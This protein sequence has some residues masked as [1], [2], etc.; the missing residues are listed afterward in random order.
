MADRLA[1]DVTPL[2]SVAMPVYNAGD[3]LRKAV[4]SIL[5]QT[6]THWEL[7]IIDDGSTDLALQT[8]KDFVDPR[9]RIF[10][11]GTN[12]G[13][14]AR[15]NEAMYLARGQF[16]ARMDQDDVSYPSRFAR[17]LQ[18][19]QQNPR[20]DV[21]A[22][23]A[24]TIDE[25]DAMTGLF[26]YAIS[27]RE[28]GA[29][30]WR[31]FYFPHPTWMGKIEWFRKHRYAVPAPYFCED[32]ELLLRTYPESQFATVNEILFG[33]RVRSQVDFRKLQKTRLAVFKI[34]WRCFGNT[35]Q[36]GYMLLA[37]ATLAGRIVRDHMSRIGP[38]FCRSSPRI[39]NDDVSTQ[40]R[41]VLDQLADLD[42]GAKPRLGSHQ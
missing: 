11:D 34:Q 39:R 28:I 26:P 7:L 24:I 3:Y 8:I 41:A 31:G 9:I 20:L 2:V 35:G 14:A 40:W 1:G 32:Q 23:R 30:P 27:H 22:A 6:F 38:A 37:L 33:Y 5:N 12:R 10:H 29:R 16:F 18:A 15:L 42:R 13:L 21:V 19:L 36:P 25:N 17:Q 4:L